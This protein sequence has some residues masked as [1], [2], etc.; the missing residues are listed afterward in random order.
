MTGADLSKK[1]VTRWRVACNNLSAA[2]CDIC[3]LSAISLT[4]HPSSLWSTTS[5]MAGGKV[6]KSSSTTSS[7]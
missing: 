5:R 7:E 3:M 1:S 4:V 2:R 6:V